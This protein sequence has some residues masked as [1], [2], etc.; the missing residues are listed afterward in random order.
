MKNFINII[1]I[2]LSLHESLIKYYN[3]IFSVIRVT[4]SPS[5]WESGVYA[6]PDLHFPSGEKDPFKFE[7]KKKESER[8]G[9]NL[10]FSTSQRFIQATLSNRVIS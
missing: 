3:F 6:S 5:V 7:K 4:K 9:T 2:D 10:F 8:S 1:F